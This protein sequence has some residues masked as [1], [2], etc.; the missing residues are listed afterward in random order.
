MFDYV[1]VTLVA[2]FAF[3]TSNILSGINRPAMLAV[4]KHTNDPL[5]N[6]RNATEVMALRRFGAM[7]PN[8]PIVIPTDPGFAKPQIE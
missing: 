5:I 6:A 2:F 7:A 3:T 8:I 4:M 1:V